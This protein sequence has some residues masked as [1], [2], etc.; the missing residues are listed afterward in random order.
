MSEPV[1]E[2]QI[3]IQ[4][5]QATFRMDGDGRWCN[6]DGP[7]RHRRIIDHFNAAIEKDE[8]GYFV[9]QNTGASVEKVYFHYEETALF[10]VEILWGVHNRM[11]LNTGRVV[12]LLPK[13]LFVHGD[14]LYYRLN[15]EFAK[16]NQ[17]AL[18]A[19]SRA[20]SCTAD[21]YRY[22]DGSVS[23]PINEAPLPR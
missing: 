3:V 23:V 13:H 2:R 11:R 9:I 18:V 12:G 6:R 15:G 10:V 5:N 4:K 1:S 7:F 20:L 14:H 21:G 22:T 8:A 16:F 19:M 17:N